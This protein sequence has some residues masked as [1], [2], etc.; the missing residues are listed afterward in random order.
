[1]RKRDGLSR[2]EKGYIA[3]SPPSQIAFALYFTLHKSRRFFDFDAFVGVRN[4]DESIEQTVDSQ[5][6]WQLKHNYFS[7]RRYYVDLFAEMVKIIKRLKPVRG[8]ETLLRSVFGSEARA[9]K[10]IFRPPT[11]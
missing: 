10:R 6:G 11:S 8:E 2:H 3:F 7:K 4:E 5:F 9:A 1:M